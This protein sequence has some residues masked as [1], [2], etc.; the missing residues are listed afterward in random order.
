MPYAWPF[1]EPKAMSYRGGTTTGTKVTLESN[2]SPAWKALQAERQS[3]KAKDRL[4]ILAMA[5][6]YRVS[7]QFVETMGFD[8]DYSPARPYFSWATEQVRVLEDREDFI[9]LQHTLVMYFQDKSG[10]VEGPMV[11]KHWRQDWSYE[12]TDLHTFIGGRSWQRTTR[13]KDSATGSWTQAVFQ[14]DDSPRY[15]VIGK[16]NHS[17]GVSRWCSEDC[18]RPLP[19]REFS[20]RDDYNVLGGTQ[21]ITITPT[22]W[23]HAQDNRK[24]IV[25]D[26][27]PVKHLASETGINRYQRITSPNLKT[28]ADEYWAASADYWSEVRKKWAEVFRDRDKFTLRDKV[29][30]KSLFMFHFGYAA[31]I[32]ETSSYDEEAGCKHARETIQRFLK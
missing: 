8:D 23:V 14:V 32:E 9:S 7:F 27:T 5:G 6:N 4:A 12:D 22:G 28:A 24:L 19:R 16:W 20:V 25:M 21:T 13:E 3:T 1:L 2:T 30:G 10:M 15:E 31:K 29:D 17:E 18:W 26:D 11:M